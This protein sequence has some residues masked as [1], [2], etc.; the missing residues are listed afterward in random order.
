MLQLPPFHNE[1]FSFFLKTQPKTKLL[2]LTGAGSSNLPACYVISTAFM[3]LSGPQFPRLK[4]E[5]VKGLISNLTPPLSVFLKQVL[6]I[7]LK[8]CIRGLC[9][10]NP[11]T[12]PR[13]RQ[14]QR[15][16]SPPI[17]TFLLTQQTAPDV[18]VGA[19]PP[20]MKA[21]FSSLSH[22]L[23]GLGIMLW[24]TGQMGRV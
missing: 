13:E 3:N 24:P 23:C 9:V 16:R 1:P 7:I 8:P 10:I 20:S 6:A 17:P 2:P 14:G 22:V 18:D 12:H 5:G 19:G 21:T 4:K 11:I 15:E